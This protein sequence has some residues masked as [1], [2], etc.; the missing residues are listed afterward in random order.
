MEM[1]VL[2]NMNVSVTDD[3]QLVR[4]GIKAVLTDNGLH[5]ITTFSNTAETLRA[6]DDGQVFDFYIVD[7]ELPDTDGFELIREIRDRQP[8][9]RI[10]VSTVHDEVWTLHRLLLL[11]VDAVIYKSG[12]SEEI[13]EAMERILRGQ[14]YYCKEARQEMKLADDSSRHPTEREMEVLCLIAEGKTT[15]EIAGTLFVSE[16]TIEAHRKSLFHKLG[17]VN[18]ADLLMK[19]VDQGYIKRHCRR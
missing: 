17:A 15:K 13:I 11:D 4:E 16:N 6:L 2:T 9:A 3:H 14:K 5:Y 18:V 7:L 1:S 19:A 8:G 12:A 10:I